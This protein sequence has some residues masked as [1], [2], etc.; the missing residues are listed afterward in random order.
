MSSF[1]IC[2]LTLIVGYFVYGRDVERVF[3]PDFNRQ[4]PALS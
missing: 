1:T 3:G 4:T 2:L